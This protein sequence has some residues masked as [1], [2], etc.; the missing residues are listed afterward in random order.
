MTSVPHPAAYVVPSGALLVFFAITFSI[1]WAVIGGYIFLPDIFTSM[2]GEIRGGHPLYFLATWGPAISAFL[3]VL[4]Y[5][6][7]HGLRRFLS[8]V[9]MWRCGAVWWL[10]ILVGTPLV[11][12]AGS[13]I[14]GGPFFGPVPPEGPLEAARVDEG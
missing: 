12:V 5:G 13:L 2:F 7:L 3:I 4:A 10:F 1:T 14:K 6:G 9:L 11:F 8:R